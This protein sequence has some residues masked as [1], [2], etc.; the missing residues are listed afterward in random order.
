MDLVSGIMDRS[1]SRGH[2]KHY[3]VGEMESMECCRISPGDTLAGVI[4]ASCL[5]NRKG[6]IPRI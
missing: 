3:K 5:G 2:N 1:R 6:P 4:V